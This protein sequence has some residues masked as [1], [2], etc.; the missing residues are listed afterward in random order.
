MAKKPTA[1]PA[2]KPDPVE[3]P[4]PGLPTIPTVDPGAPDTATDTPV[5][6]G[7]PATTVLPSPATLPEGVGPTAESTI[8]RATGT[9]LERRSADVTAISQGREEVPASVD[10]VHGIGTQVVSDR[11]EPAAYHGLGRAAAEPLP[12][13]ASLEAEVGRD[14]VRPVRPGYLRVSCAMHRRRAGYA[15]G[16]TPIDIPLD[17]LT[18]DERRAIENDPLLTVKVG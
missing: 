6:A 7:T 5:V 2:T 4:A 10:G 16:P 12:I 13:A 1:T 11:V 18:T 3:K 8:D 14:E 9:I 17:R 15:F